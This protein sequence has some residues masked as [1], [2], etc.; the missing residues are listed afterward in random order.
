MGCNNQFIQI[1]S[2][3]VSELEISETNV[4]DDDLEFKTKLTQCFSQNKES[5][6]PIL[7]CVKLNNSLIKEIEGKL[8]ID[9]LATNTYPNKPKKSQYLAT[10]DFE[11][12]E[13]GKNYKKIKL[14]DC[15]LEGEL[16]SIYMKND[17]I[18]R[19]NNGNYWRVN[20]SYFERCYCFS[21][22]ESP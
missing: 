4:I 17:L 13:L 6:E 20:D 22:R 14:S 19:F 8:L 1:E 10:C 15:E 7:N 16:T 18:N 2:Q 21:F 5:I 11:Y 12:V 9:Q 3:N